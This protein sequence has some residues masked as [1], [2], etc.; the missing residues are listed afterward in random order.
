MKKIYILLFITTLIFGCEENDDVPAQPFV[1]AFEKLSVNLSTITEDSEIAIVFSEEAFGS[2]EIIVQVSSGEAV[3]GEDYATIP[4]TESNQII[5]PFS[6]GDDQTSFTFQPLMYPYTIDDNNTSITFEIIGINYSGYSNIQGYT[7]TILSFETSL[8]AVISPEVGGP[9]EGDQVFI[10]LSTEEVTSAQRD[11]WDLGFYG[12]DE[13]RVKI[14]GSIYMAAAELESTD[15]DAVSLADVEEIQSSVAVGT[16][17]PN[18][19]A[20]IDDPSG[21]ISGTA[22]NEIS[23]T[24][25]DN[26][27]YLINMGYY[28]GTETPAAGSVAIAGEH[29]GWKKVRILQT[30]DSYILQYADIDATTHS[31]VTIAK[32]DAYNFSFFSLEDETVVTV[33]PEKTN[34]DISFTVFTNIIDGAGSYG[35]S[36]FVITNVVGGVTAYEMS[37]DDVSY[38]DFSFENIDEIN[39]SDDQRIIGADWRDVFSGGVYN[40]RFYVLK[41]VEGNYYKIKMLALLSESGERGYPEFEY[42]L[43]N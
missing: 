22:I 41:D 16:F 3:Y 24:D 40:D 12:G 39:L 18:N 20:Y 27:V 43:I 13:F 4:A 23:A 36:D 35:Y 7:S 10:D 29:R 34:W 19:E 2:G 38:A 42:Q 33:E 9:N 31:E 26:K 30:S 37:T 32:N 21:A 6:E 15:I 11:S 25:A 8:G 28:I 14:N 17:D 5:I 1:A